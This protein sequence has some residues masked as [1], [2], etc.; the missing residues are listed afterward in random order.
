[1][2]KKA[3]LVVSFGTSYYETRE[4][5]IVAIEKRLQN[6]FGDYKVYSAFT[7]KKIR[8]KLEEKGVSV[9]DVKEAVEQMFSDGMK[10][11]FVQPLFMINGG[12]YELLLEELQLYLYKFKTIK[13]GQSLLASKEDYKELAMIIGNVYPT[14]EDEVLVLMGHG[15]EH[16]MNRV[17]A[18]F[19][20]QLHQMGY[21]HILVGTI[22]AQ[23][24]FFEIKTQ[25]KKKCVRKVYL[26]PMMIVAGN[27][28][29]KD[30]L[31]EKNSWRAELEKEGYTVRYDTKSLGELSEVQEMF[32]R[33]ARENLR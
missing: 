6:V 30:M 21:G 15:L 13:C 28:V 19:Q 31:G 32:V 1:M 3:M 2:T 20:C 8:R 7:S 27:H 12:A 9:F 11:V 33:H 18:E 5:N 24:S 29:H 26:I 10:E 17:Y 4:K 14:E 16:P 25:L 22:K 23:P